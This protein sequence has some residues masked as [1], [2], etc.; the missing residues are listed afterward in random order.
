MDVIRAFSE[1]KL[2]APCEVSQSPSRD[3]TNTSRRRWMSLVGV[4]VI[5]ALSEHKLKAPCEV[6]AKADKTYPASFPKNREVK[7][8]MDT[9]HA[10]QI[11]I[12]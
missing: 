8:C 1:H 12:L 11:Q 7:A 5:R 9:L 4:D 6:S 3:L 10:A 2:K